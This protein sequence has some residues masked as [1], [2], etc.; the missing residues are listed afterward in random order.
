MDIFVL[1]YIKQYHIKQCH[2]KQYYININQLEL[3][4]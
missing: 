2:I 4:F 3:T 1:N